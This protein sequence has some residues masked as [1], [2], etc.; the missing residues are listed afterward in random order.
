PREKPERFQARQAVVDEYLEKYPFLAD[1][2]HLGR[3]RRLAVA[4]HHAGHLPHYKLMIEDLMSRGL[5]EA[6]F[7]TSTVSAGV[8]F[9]ARTVV[10]R[11]S[12]RFDG[13]GFSDLTA[14]EFTQ[15][16]G[17]AGR[18]GRDNIGFALMI[19]GPHM[20]LGLMNTLM[21]APP[22]PVKSSLT[23]NF[24]MVLNLLNAYRPQE[25]R[26]LLTG[27]LAVWQ[28]AACGNERPSEA[29]L[30]R[31]S[32]DVFESFQKYLDFL[33]QEKLVTRKDALT[34]DGRWAAELRLDHPLVFYAGI[35]AGAWPLDPA[36]LA[37]AVA[38]LVSDRE[39]NKPLPRRKPPVRLA[40]ALTALAL[41]TG[42]M[43]N[44][45]EE[46]GFDTPVFNMRP[47]WAVWSW[48]ARGDFDEATELLGLGAGDM[49]MLALRAA[50]HLRQMAGLRGGDHVALAQA[51]REAVYHLLKEPVSSPL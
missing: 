4:A 2:S 45:L 46:A 30:S 29:A 39:S 32:K 44:R 12:D 17:R 27:S 10:I 37:A 13:Q 42:P 35:K 9:P 48:A 43:I 41:A 14:N 8:N 7:A 16:T 51:A 49:A 20:N 1:H 15:M 3:V 23:I 33:K 11:Q 21:S 47:A 34:A 26:R 38:G 22:D 6:I 24:S 31:A 5:L 28:E 25:A 18:R 36:A 40:G 19:P 50:D